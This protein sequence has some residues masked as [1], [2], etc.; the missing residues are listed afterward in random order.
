MPA[1]DEARS[2]LEEMFEA[3]VDA[4]RAQTTLP[5]ALPE[6]EEGGRIIL[7]AAGKGAGA[8]TEVAEAAYLDSYSLPPERLYGLA[9]TRHGYARPTRQIEMIEAGHPVPDEAGRK[10]SARA[11]EMARNAG[12]GDHVVVLLSGGG[13]ANW[14]APIDGVSF[15]EKQDLTRALLKS[16][17]TIDE[18]NTVRK[19]LSL[20]KGG[21]LAAALGE[22]ARLTTLAVSDV[23]HDN[24]A[25]IASGPTVP[26]P[27]TLADARAV[28]ER[29]RIDIPAS[30][31]DALNNPE[32]ETPKPGDAIF[33]RAD[34]RL[35]A[36]PQ[37]SLDAAAGIAMR[38]GFE[39]IQLGDSIEGEARDVAD[40]HA[41]L[42]ILLAGEGRKAVLLS[43]GELTVTIRG[44]GRGGP[45]QEY[46]LALAI[47]LQGHPSVAALAGDTDG[48][49]GGT[50]AADDP[51]GAIV[52]PLTLSRAKAFDLDAAAFL[53]RNDSTAFFSAI[54]DLVRPGPTMTNVND[55]RVVLIDNSLG[56]QQ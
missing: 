28:I 22:G 44:D 31:R 5:P 29:Y 23:P 16:G 55:F 20:I 40:E 53:S 54:G 52:D 15:A 7:L 24:P 17:A 3:A 12:S 21:R 43:G 27:T 30:V 35:V 1:Y 39:V 11:I 33:E 34:Y 47:A 10:A 51:A 38:A 37:I 42:A 49:D 6:P 50:G 46:A 18:I 25:V 19:H 36:R 32:N 13:S 56:R 48:T 26:D 2:L 45:N 9:V 4:A 8:M 14:S 41:K